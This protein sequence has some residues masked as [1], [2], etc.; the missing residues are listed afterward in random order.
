[1]SSISKSAAI[2]VVLLVTIIEDAGLI[3][4]LILARGSTLYAGIPIAA[5]VLLVVL[6]I[7]HSIMQRA[8]NPNFTRRVFVQIV[9]FSSLEVVNWSVWLALLGN[10]TSLFTMSSLI[11]AVYFFVGFYIEHQITE[12][13]ITQQP[14]LHFRNSKGVI[15]AGVILET[16]SEG[17]GARLWIFLIPIMGVT[18]VALLLVGSTIEHSI[19]FVVGRVPVGSEVAQVTS[20]QSL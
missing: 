4:W 18:A 20:R 2:G 6:L 19:Q 5:L 7:E 17:I 15:T 10:T 1:M 12:N 13:V 16:L 11:A 9:G 3:L 8:E 14:F